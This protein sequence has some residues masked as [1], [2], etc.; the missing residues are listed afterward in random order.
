MRTLAVVCPVYNEEDVI[1]AFHEELRRSLATLEGPWSWSVVYVVDR[2]TDHTLERLRGLSAADP[3][4]RVLALSAHFGQQASLLAGLDHCDADAVVM[5]DADLQHPPSLVPELVA[6]HERGYDVVYTVREDTPDIPFLK[7]LTA[8][9]FYRFVNALSETPIR[10][11][12][13]DFRLVSRRVVEIFQG[14][15]RERGL[16]LRGLFAWVGFPSCPVRFRVGARRAGRTKYSLGRMVR[17]GLGGVVGFSR[18]PLRAA[19]V[20]GIALG[21]LGALLLAAA[22][23]RS[24]TTQAPFFSGEAL[25]G[26]VV[27][28]SGVQLVFL[29]V[30][31]EYLGAVL[32]EVKARPHYLVQERINLEPRQ[33]TER[34]SRLR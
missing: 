7:R 28:L 32:D 25:V 18:V 33:A 12:A 4:V 13:A 9:W 10:E 24:L 19:F 1:V 6:A 21:A 8:R 22:L 27:G 15:I 29:G 23:G 2:G 34:D 26:L 17:F 11:G 5:M 20:L 3:S 31:G 30:L 16:F 14:G